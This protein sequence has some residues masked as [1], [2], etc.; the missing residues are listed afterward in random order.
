MTVQVLKG[1]PT[2]IRNGAVYHEL[3]KAD[4]TTHLAS[5]VI[6]DSFKYVFNDSTFTVDLVTNSYKYGSELQF[7]AYSRRPPVLK[8]RVEKDHAYYR[9]E[10][11][12]LPVNY[13]TVR[14]LENLAY[15]LRAYLDL[16]DLE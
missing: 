12:Y 11:G 6:N 14:W 2:R 10:A 5:A 9:L 4:S 16:K 1:Y 15:S 8:P 7:K 3:L 13:G